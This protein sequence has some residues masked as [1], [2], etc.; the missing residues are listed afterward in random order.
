MIRVLLLA[1]NKDGVLLMKI[2]GD[3]CVWSLAH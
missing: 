1:I 3:Y 2:C